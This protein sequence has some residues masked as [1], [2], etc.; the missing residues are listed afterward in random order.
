MLTLRYNEPVF[1]LMLRG[2]VGCLRN[3]H[4]FVF[5]QNGGI[6]LTLQR[7]NE[8]RCRP[9]TAFPFILDSVRSSLIGAG[10]AAS[11]HRGS[12]LRVTKVPK[13][14][15][16]LNNFFNNSGNFGGPPSYIGG[17]I[18]Y[19]EC[20]TGCNQDVIGVCNEVHFLS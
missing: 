7:F 14:T 6:L 5:S 19:S 9:L 1:I 4:Y 2:R 3:N 15:T 10:I 8:N 16:I 13:F 12:A 11:S 20:A 18:H 17:S